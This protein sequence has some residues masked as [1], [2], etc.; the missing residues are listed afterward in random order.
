MVHFE[1][2]VYVGGG[3]AMF[4]FRRGQHGLAP[5]LILKFLFELEIM[6]VRQWGV[7]VCT[8]PVKD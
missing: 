4:V 8:I 2:C 1:V 7:D 6:I 3:G 5:A